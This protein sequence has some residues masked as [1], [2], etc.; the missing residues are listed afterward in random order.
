MEWWRQRFAIS[1]AHWSLE[2]CFLSTEVG[3]HVSELPKTIKHVSLVLEK[4]YCAS[5]WV[6]PLERMAE[7]L[8]RPRMKTGI[9]ISYRE[10]GILGSQVRWNCR[11]REQRK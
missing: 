7:R 5:V 6:E 1:D 11:V 8:F 10:R 9:V 3:K 4:T 2:D